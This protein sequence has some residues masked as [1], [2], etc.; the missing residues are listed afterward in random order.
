MK[1]AMTHFDFP[2]TIPTT[3]TGI[4]LTAILLEN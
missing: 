2:T 4:I 1:A 3:Y